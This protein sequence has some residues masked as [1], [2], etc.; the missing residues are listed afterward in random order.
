MTLEEAL[1]KLAYAI[2]TLAN[3]RGGIKERLG[4]ATARDL[5][6]VRSEELPETA[7]PYFDAAMHSLSTIR[8]KR[9]SLRETLSAMSEE[10]AQSVANDIVAAY[11]EARHHHPE[12]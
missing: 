7:R 9:A 1:R 11:M 10:E 12:K 8:G 6:K 2:N 3:G 4:D 5:L